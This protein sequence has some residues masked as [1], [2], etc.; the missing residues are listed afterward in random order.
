MPK[1]RIQ[2]LDTFAHPFSRAYW[3]LAASEMSSTKMLV[4][5]ALM[6]ALRIALKTVSIPIGDNLNIGVQFLVNAYGAMVM[7]P[8]L[9]ML[10]ALVTD[11]LGFVLHPDGVYFPLFA[12]TEM[13]GALVFALTFYRAKLT[14]KRVTLARFTVNVLVNIV[15]QTPVM[16][17]YYHLMLGRNYT[18]FNA[19][20]IFKNLALFPIEAVLL[21]FFLRMTIPPTRRMGFFVSPIDDLK[22]S[23]KNVAMLAGLTLLGIAMV[24]VYLFLRTKG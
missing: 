1:M 10:T 12:L 19:M 13:A 17:A 15:L 9:A 7:G 3:R 4:F 14:V 20:R 5:A 2:S 24:L 18:L 11:V 16:A 6:A 8:V 22:I 21:V 23:P